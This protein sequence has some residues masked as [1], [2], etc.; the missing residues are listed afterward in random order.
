[1]DVLGNNKGDPILVES[2]I[3]ALDGKVSGVPTVEAILKL[4]TL[5]E[6][7]VVKLGVFAD[8][9]HLSDVN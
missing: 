6:L 1:M 9:D 4:R 5:D 2:D 7:T 3:L 8:A